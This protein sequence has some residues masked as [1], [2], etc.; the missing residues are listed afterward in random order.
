[1]IFRLRE[2][3]YPEKSS[4]PRKKSTPEKVYPGK[5]PQ[6]WSNQAYIGETLSTQKMNIFTK[7]HK[8]W[9]AIVNFLLI[10]KFLASAIFYAPPSTNLLTYLRVLRSDHHHT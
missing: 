5:N 1:M 3:F 10:A 2:K 8:D 4:T 6:F 7:F 9:T